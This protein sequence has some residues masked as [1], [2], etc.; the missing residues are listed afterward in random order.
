MWGRARKGRV[1]QKRS[2]AVGQKDDA[3]PG[4][5]LMS[6]VVVALMAVLLLLMPWSEQYSALDNFPHGQDTEVSLLGFFI[7][8]GLTL[9]FARSRN[10]A[11]GAL[12]VV[13]F[14]FVSV[15]GGAGPLARERVPGYALST[16]AG[17]PL[18]SGSPGA[19][20]VPLQI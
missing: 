6:R 8:L 17:P 16:P 11:V 19:F 13:V 14:V 18:P 10:K 1:S 20:R 3:L 5:V 2:N 7:I 4:F 12:L 15:A 9:L